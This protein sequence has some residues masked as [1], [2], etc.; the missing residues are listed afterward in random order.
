MTGEK[1]RFGGRVA[2]VTGGAQGIGFGIARHLA[3]GG[4]KI[5]VLDINAEGAERAVSALRAEGAE[6]L[7]APCDITDFASVSAA[8]ARAEAGLGPVD[9]LVNNAGWSPNKPFTETSQEEWQ[10]IIAVNYVGVLNGCRAVLDGMI[11]REHGRIVCISSDAARVGTPREAVYAGAKAGVIG[12]AKSLAAEAAR[13]QVTVNV[14]CPS[15]TDTPLLRA[16]LSEEQL[17]RRIQGNPMRRIGQPEDIAG[18]VAFFASD[19]AAYV[20]GQVLSVNGGSSRVG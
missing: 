12:F 4:A 18:A 5:G 3:R 16:I 1:A 9:I 13:Y 17:Q 11:A 20:T 19:E 8:I 7:A 6:A 2:L 14:V 10:R 15:T